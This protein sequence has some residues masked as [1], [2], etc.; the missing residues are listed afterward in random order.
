MTAAPQWLLASFVRSVT[1][2]GA[3]AGRERIEEVGRDLLERWQTPDRHFHNVRHLMDVLT[4]VDELSPETHAPHAVRLAA[5][6]HGAVFSAARQQ[7]YRRRAGEDKAASAALAREQ[8]AALGVATSV[9]HRVGGL[10]AAI[11]RH[12]A[13]G[14]DR[15]ALALSDADLGMLAAEPQRYA[16]YRRAVREEYAHVPTRDYLDSRIEV[17][18]RLLA[19]RR[20]FASPMTAGWE[21]PARQNLA[22][23]LS[24]LRETRAVSARSADHPGAEQDRAVDEE[25]LAHPAPAAPAPSAATPAAPASSSAE[26]APV[27]AHE[28]RTP[29]RHGIEREPDLEPERRAERRKRS[30]RNRKPTPPP[31]EGDPTG[32]LLRPPPKMPRP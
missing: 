22:A 27:G 16:A 14:A 30:R 7:A 32:S 9:T 5:W 28:E 3:T 25:P 17:L 29:P 23:E 1:A 6:Y 2:V 15:D 13:D 24:L 4:H 20:I 19:R 18:E 21:E 10:V 12:D 11:A 31:A 26:A 8:L